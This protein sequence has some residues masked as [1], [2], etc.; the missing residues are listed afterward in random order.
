MVFV[1][2]ATFTMA[3]EA[4]DGSGAHAH[5]VTIT[6]GFFIDKT[7]VTAGAYAECV[8]AGQCTP[9]SIH[10]P[11]A[12]PKQIEELSQVC[13][14]NDPAKQNYP[15]NCIDYQQAVTYCSVQSKRL[16]TEAEWELAARG[17][18]N[19]TYPW[20]ETAPI[21]CDLAAMSGCIKKLGEVALRPKGASPFG[22]LDMA[23]NV[24]EWVEETYNDKPETLG[25]TDPHGPAPKFVG[26]LRGGSWDFAA[27]SSRA[28]SRLKFS[29]G[30][31]H[32]STGVR[33]A[34]SQ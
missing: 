21:G 19:R 34:K 9:T 16:P 10:G 17:T 32:V 22:A 5:Q 8:T 12:S 3:A 20:G 30:S 7:E 33:C 26:T 2:A 1:P 11:A 24:W 15:I 23:G 28:F 6:R 4:P 14:A 25:N 29:S 27:K 31:G 13:T 18:D